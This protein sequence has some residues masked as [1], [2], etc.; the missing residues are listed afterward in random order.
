MYSVPLTLECFITPKVTKCLNLLKILIDC[1]YIICGNWLLPITTIKCI[2]IVVLWPWKI[3]KHQLLYALEYIQSMS[4]SVKN[5]DTK[6]AV[7]NY[8]QGLKK[9]WV[10]ACP[11]GKQLSHFGHFLPFLHMILFEDDLP[12]PLPIGHRSRHGMARVKAPPS[13]G[14]FHM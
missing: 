5:S 14:K 7:V 1:T 2:T 4:W 10:L 11:L 13:H 12:R 6:I 3:G 9:T 8:L